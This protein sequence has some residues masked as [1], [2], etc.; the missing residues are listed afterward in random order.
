MENEMNVAEPRH[1]KHLDLR[2]FWLR[3]EVEKK[4]ISISYC[5]TDRMP[6]DIMTKSLGRIKVKECAAMLGLTW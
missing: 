2:F 6:A 4:T 3:D 5:P 1:M